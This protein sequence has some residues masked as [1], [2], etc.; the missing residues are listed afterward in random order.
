VLCYLEGLTYAAGAH[1]LGLSEVA[2]RGRLARARERLRRRL[3]RRGVTVPSGLLVV[4]T[5][6]EVQAIPV[7]LIHSTIRIALGFVAG[8]SAAVLAL[9]VLN[10]MLLKQV[11]VAAVLSC[12]GIGGIV[13]AWYA[14]DAAANEES[15][16]RSGQGFGKASAN[17]RPSIE[18]RKRVVALTPPAPMTTPITVRGRAIDPAG[19]PVAGATIHLFST[20]GKNVQL[21]TTTTDRDGLY[22]FRNTRLP[23]SRSQDDAPLEGTFQVYGTAAGYGFAWHGMR[24]YQPRRRPDDRKVTGEDYT[25]FGGDPKVMDLR[26]SPA[27]VLSGRIV[28]E[29]GRPVPDARIRIGQCDYLD[30]EG[31]ESHPNF[32]EFWAIDDAPAALTTTKTNSD[33]RFRLAGLPKE[34]GFRIYI[35]HP[36]YAWLNLFAVTSSRPTTAFEYPGQ[37]TIGH[38]REPVATGELNLTVNSTRQIDVRSTFAGSG[39]T[40]PRVRVTASQGSGVS[41]YGANGITDGNGKLQFCL[42]PGEYD[43][44]SDPT[45]GGADCIRTLSNFKV[46]ANPAEQLLEVR[47]NP[48]CVLILEAVDSKTGKG[49]PGVQFLRETEDNP[50]AR[51]SVQ[52]RTGYVDNPVS[53]SNGRIRAVVNPGAGVFSVGHMPESAGYR[54]SSLEKKVALPAGQT[55]TLRFE[56]E[57]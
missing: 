20:H 37:S 28:D 5:T 31:K 6:G 8:N 51:I 2:L 9:G 34:A 33:G 35:E 4:A 12:L 46:V 43:I 15:R 24:S 54:P 26:F 25:F 44:R 52:L 7:A 36:K 13:W 1:Q 49:I 18:P 23:V 42:P 16:I 38:V 39:R 32:R 29:T 48:A 45:I 50:G 56:L 53:D 19:N 11:K 22:F 10:S 55:V 30:T 47:V 21:D 41:G 3:I 40:A 57:K 27:A 17:S 14:F